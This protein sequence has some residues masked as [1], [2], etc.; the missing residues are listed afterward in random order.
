MFDLFIYFILSSNPFSKNVA[1]SNS[2]DDCES[3]VLK[4]YL[5]ELITPTPR[6]LLNDA[7]TYSQSEPNLLYF[8]VRIR[9][10]IDQIVQSSTLPT[11]L[12]AIRVC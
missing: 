11:S 8:H 10:I 3:T 9:E 7:L 6:Q 4:H 5:K 12:T 2:T 1:T